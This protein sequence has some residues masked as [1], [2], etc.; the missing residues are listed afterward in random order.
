MTYLGQ[1]DADVDT[2]VI[3][4]PFSNSILPLFHTRIPCL[5]TWVGSHNRVQSVSSL[6]VDALFARIPM[7]TLSLKMAVM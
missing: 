3:F 4:D 2:P 5:S 6:A 1:T 7:L